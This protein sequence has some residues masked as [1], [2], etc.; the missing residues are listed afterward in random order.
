MFKPGK[1]GNS[2]GRP[3]GSGRKRID[4]NEI[5]KNIEYTDKEGIFHKGFDP[6][7]QLAILGATAKSEKVRREACSDLAPF[8]APK[9]KS[10]EHTGASDA[11]VT[12]KLVLGNADE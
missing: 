9:L 1:S 10:I 5:L 4:V 12:I 3:V 11:P 7:R 2:K 6:L 8:I